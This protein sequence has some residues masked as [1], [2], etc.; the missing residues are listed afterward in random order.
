MISLISS[1]WEEE[2]EILLETRRRE[3]RVHAVRTETEATCRQVNSEHTGP[4]SALYR[5]DHVNALA[6]K[7]Q[8]K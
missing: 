8:S 7:N 5:G 6:N 4:L 3:G 1:T 2:G